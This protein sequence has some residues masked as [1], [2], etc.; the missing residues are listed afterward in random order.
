M[1]ELEMFKFLEFELH[2]VG[3]VGPSLEIVENIVLEEMLQVE[4]V[5]DEECGSKKGALDAIVDII[6]CESK[7]LSSISLCIIFK[8][9][10]LC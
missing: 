10:F 4:N 3:I 5:V 9:F 2:V 8:W 7:V 6:D 1:N